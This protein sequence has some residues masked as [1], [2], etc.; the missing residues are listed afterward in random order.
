MGARRIGVC[1]GGH[2]RGGREHW[3]PSP[4]PNQSRE[5]QRAQMLHFSFFRTAP[6]GLPAWGHKKS[7]KPNRPEEA[8]QQAPFLRGCDGLN[9][10]LAQKIEGIPAG[11]S[12]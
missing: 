2:G 10:D 11:A 5:P 9:A 3:P 8:F 7:K 4:A 1:V 12:S 6:E